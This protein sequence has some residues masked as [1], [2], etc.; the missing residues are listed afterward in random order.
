M[1]NM[2]KT[3][4]VI[5]DE[6]GY[7]VLLSSDLGRYEYTVL[8]AASG[9]EALK[10]L[11]ESK[12]DVIITDM[13]MSPMDGLDTIIAIKKIH[14]RL[15]IVIM[16]GYAVEERVRQALEFKPSTC[17]HKPFEINEMRNTVRE[18]VGADTTP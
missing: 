2:S 5:D 9:P 11:K 8:T 12:V 4:L 1:E 16:T 3:I 14:P 10:I 13:K 6:P 17:L 15:P 18:L 7:R